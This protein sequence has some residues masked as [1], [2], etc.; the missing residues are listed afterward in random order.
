MPERRLICINAPPH[1]PDLWWESNLVLRQKGGKADC[2]NEHK[3]KESSCRSPWRLGTNFCWVKRLIGFGGNIFQCDPSSAPCCFKLYVIASPELLGIK[4]VKPIPRKRSITPKWKH[5]LRTHI[6]DHV[7][8]RPFEWMLC[9]SQDLGPVDAWDT[10]LGL[11]AFSDYSLTFPDHNL[12][13]SISHPN[14]ICF[15][16]SL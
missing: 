8:P 12:P 11:D 2:D 16:L 9:P 5:P 6:L 3:C 13:L 15:F 10:S 4:W 7:G 1:P 14:V